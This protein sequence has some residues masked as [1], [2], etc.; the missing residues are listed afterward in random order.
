M[1]MGIVFDELKNGGFVIRESVTETCIGECWSFAGYVETMRNA[2]LDPFDNLRKEDFVDTFASPE[3]KRLIHLFLD[4]C[5]RC[6][7]HLV[8]CNCT[9][10][11][12]LKW[13]K[14]KYPQ[15]FR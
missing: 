2:F 14:E 5:K 11:L 13:A 12:D 7:E 6:G 4:E 10:R 8:D 15:L 3:D 1:T 9:D